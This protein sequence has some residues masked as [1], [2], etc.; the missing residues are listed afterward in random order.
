VGK[1]S[2]FA[3]FAGKAGILIRSIKLFAAGIGKRYVVG[4]IEEGIE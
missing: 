3:D 4:K 1:N 2:L